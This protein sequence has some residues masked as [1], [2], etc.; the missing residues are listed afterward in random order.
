MVAGGQECRDLYSASKLRTQGE[1]GARESEKVLL[2]T[3]QDN[4]NVREMGR[5]LSV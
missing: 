3:G 2:P 5:V 4:K 1:D